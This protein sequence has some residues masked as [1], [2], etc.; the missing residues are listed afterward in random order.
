MPIKDSAVIITLAFLI[1]M[2]F[3]GRNSAFWC[4]VLKRNRIRTLV[5]TKN[6]AQDDV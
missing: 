6:I 3:Y 1:V 2:I 5:L 4:T